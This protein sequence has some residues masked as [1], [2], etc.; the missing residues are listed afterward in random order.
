MENA[1]PIQK[2]IWSSF[3]YM[4]GPELR[5]VWTADNSKIALSNST[6]NKNKLETEID[7]IE[8]ESETVDGCVSSSDSSFSKVL[9]V[10]PGIY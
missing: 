8:N 1:S 3:D 2:I 10:Y 4:A 5:F 7:Q 9:N 6:V